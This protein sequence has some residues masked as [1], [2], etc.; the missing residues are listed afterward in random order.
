MTHDYGAQLIAD[1]FFANV[2]KMNHFAASR[3]NDTIRANRALLG[4][5]RLKDDHS[6]VIIQSLLWQRYTVL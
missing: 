5:W 3:T 4:L 6:S 1:F 2:Q